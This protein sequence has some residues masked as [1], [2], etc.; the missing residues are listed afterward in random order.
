MVL[1]TRECAI[2]S[3]T[4][5]DNSLQPSGP[6]PMPSSSVQMP[7]PPT[8]SGQQ[9][10]PPETSQPPRGGGWRSALSTIAILLIAPLCAIL[11]TAFVFQSYQV[12]GPSM[13]STLQNNDRLLVWKLP[14]TW[15]RITRHAYVPHRGDII[16]FN[17][18]QLGSFGS[19]QTKQLIKRVIALPGEKVSIV[20]GTYVVYNK[21][22]PE[23]FKP[24]D[25][26]AH[27]KPMGTTEPESGQTTWTL[28]DG[29][30]FVSGDNRQDSLDSRAFGP[31]GLN[32]VIGKLSWRILPLNTATKF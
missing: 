3:I 4:M 18:S 12:D 11:L 16:I 28:G 27:G 20:D 17:E 7:V 25:Q 5:Q 19:S 26:Y 21:E 31:V 32:D 14:R 10:P 23:G 29:E 8:P 6:T 2:V 9:L 1:F 22:H 30:I 15:S 24:D 13:E